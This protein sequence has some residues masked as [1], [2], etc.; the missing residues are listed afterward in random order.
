MAVFAA[1]C[2]TTML[3]AVNLH[4]GPYGVGT[5]SA[6]VPA[7]QFALIMTAL[8]VVFSL[9][10]VGEPKFVTVVFL[11]TAVVLADGFPIAYSLFDY[12]EAGNVGRQVLGTGCLYALGG[13]VLI[14]TAVSAVLSAGVS[15]Q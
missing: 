14:R 13:V 11:R 12:D 2:I 7:V 15:L 5:T 4:L 3:L 6:V 1:C 10:R 8:G 9:F